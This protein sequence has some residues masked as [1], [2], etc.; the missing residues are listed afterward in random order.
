MRT[1]F[2]GVGDG[3]QDMFGKPNERTRTSVPIKKSA[4]PKKPS[5]SVDLLVK[6]VIYSDG[7]RETYS[8]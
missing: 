1:A 2:S 3:L 8:E 5:L 7:T 4:S 6:E